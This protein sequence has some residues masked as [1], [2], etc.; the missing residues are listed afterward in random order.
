[1]KNLSAARAK[2]VQDMLQS[3]ETMPA[4]Q[5]KNR[6]VKSN[7]VRTLAS[8]ILWGVYEENDTLLRPFAVDANARCLDLNGAEICL[9]DDDRI[10][11]VDAAQLTDED[12]EAWRVFFWK[13]GTKAVV[14]QFEAPARYVSSRFVPRRYMDLTFGMG[15]ACNVLGYNPYSDGD[16]TIVG[17]YLRVIATP[18]ERG[19][20]GEDK[21]KVYHAQ[22]EKPL[23]AFSAMTDHQKRLFNRDLIRLDS[24]L[25]PQKKAEEA[26]ASGSQEEIGIL[27]DMRLITPDNITQMLGIAMDKKNTDAVSYLMQ[28]KQDWLGDVS[29]PFAEFTLDD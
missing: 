7:M 3:G 28:L 20:V 1:V 4:K 13:K 17:N 15:Y 18:C 24:V 22:I 29:D 27:A 21:M 12:L 16:A 2:S 9:A 10:G 26:V 5:W 11:V 19:L 8:G 25:H 14:R 23:P 6:Y